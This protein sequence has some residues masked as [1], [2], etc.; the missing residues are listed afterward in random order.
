MCD[1]ISAAEAS[2]AAYPNQYDGAY[3]NKRGLE[4]LSDSQEKMSSQSW[5][6]SSSTD[7]ETKVKTKRPR[8][9]TNK[10]RSK[11]R[12]TSSKAPIT[13]HTV[14][15]VSIMPEGLVAEYPQEEARGS[16]M[17]SVNCAQSNEQ[18]FVSSDAEFEW[19]WC[20]ELLELELFAEQASVKLA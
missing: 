6:S 10:E 4:S 7:P 9:T 20:G 17:V 18:A 16:L 15:A 19:D 13:V 11:P 12:R 2:L 3:F 14:P 8:R 5:A 1:Q